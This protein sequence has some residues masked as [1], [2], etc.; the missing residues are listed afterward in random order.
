MLRSMALL[1]PS[2][3]AEYPCVKPSRSESRSRAIE[4]VE[5][6]LRHVEARARLE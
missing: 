1:P 2:M 6:R 4:E 3:P 5:L